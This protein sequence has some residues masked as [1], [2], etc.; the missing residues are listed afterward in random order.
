VIP[1]SGFCSTNT[2]PIP[3]T[4]CYMSVPPYSPTHSDF[5]TLAFPNTG[6]LSLTR[7]R[8]CPSTDA[9]QVH[10]LRHMHLESWLPLCVP[11]G[12]WFSPW[13]LWGG[14]VSWY[15]CS[16]YGVA[17][18]FSSFSL[19]PNSSIGVPVLSPMFGCEHPSLYLSGSGKVFLETAISDSCQQAGLGALN[20][21]WVWCL[22]RGW[23]PR[24]GNLWMVFPLGSACHLATV[25]PLDRI[26]C[27]LKILRWVGNPI[28]QPG[29][30]Y[31]LWIWS[32]QV[33]LPYIIFI[34]KC[35]WLLF[36]PLLSLSSGWTFLSVVSFYLYSFCKLGGK[37]VL[38]SKKYIYRCHFC[39]TQY[40]LHDLS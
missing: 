5:T 10:P 1:F 33:L 22:Y 37:V 21:V 30:L 23:I 27:R 16:S 7:P 12:W 18:T 28:L 13:E 6:V 29:T 8:N 24:W 3:P 38:I 17:N 31:K 9:R 26:S 32:L 34:F 36:P 15:S 11:F 14:L 2:H 39:S 40:Y 4:I 20:S 25:I 19:L 35:C